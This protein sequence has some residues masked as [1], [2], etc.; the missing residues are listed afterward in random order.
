MITMQRERQSGFTLIELIIALSITVVMVAVGVPRYN[1]FV[2]RQDFISN[3]QKV[4]NCLQTAQR[5]ATAP[6]N[7]L[8]L[9][10][11]YV[12]FYLDGPPHPLTC[13]VFDADAAGYQQQDLFD[14]NTIDKISVTNVS[15]LGTSYALNFPLRVIFGNLEHGAP[16]ELD[17][18]NQLIVS[19]ATVP[20]GKGFSMELQVV[21]TEI[22]GMSAIITMERLG[23]PI[24][25]TIKN[26]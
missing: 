7:K 3:V 5:S 13:H 26:P 17:N 21:S 12:Q 23:N 11:R 2:R 18:Q 4:A 19:P 16:L 20:Y 15:A 25:V 14:D 10:S 9:P 8:G 22:T 1:S 24:Q 6:A